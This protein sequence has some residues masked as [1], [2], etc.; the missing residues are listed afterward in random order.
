ML[1]GANDLPGANAS[2]MPVERTERIASS[3]SDGSLG[4]KYGAELHP[5]DNAGATDHSFFTESRDDSVN[6]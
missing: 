2:R 3:P 5:L 4:G 1:V 6:L